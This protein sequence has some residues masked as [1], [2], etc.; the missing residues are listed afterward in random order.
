MIILLL[1]NYIIFVYA[2]AEFS[3]SIDCT[4]IIPSI[5]ICISLVVQ[6]EN[7]ERNHLAVLDKSMW[8]L[9]FYT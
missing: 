7:G 3:I 8:Q 4:N 9:I 6:K 2:C 1:P 5:Y